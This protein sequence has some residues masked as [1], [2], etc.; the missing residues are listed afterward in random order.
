MKKQHCY[1][2]FPL[3]ATNID[4]I[5]EGMAFSRMPPFFGII[6]KFEKDVQQKESITKIHADTVISGSL[7][8][9]KMSDFFPVAQV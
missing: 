6:P 5:L 7:C 1:L 2:P 9:F 3:S 4:N 8:N